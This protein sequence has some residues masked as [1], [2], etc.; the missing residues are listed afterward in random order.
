[1]VKIVSHSQISVFWIEIT[2]ILQ[3]LIWS[4]W[5]NFGGGGLVIKSCLTLCG[6][7]DWSLLGSSVHGIFQTR[8]LEWVA[9][10]FSKGSSWPRDGTSISCMSFIGRQILYHWATWWRNF[11]EYHFRPWHPRVRESVKLS[12]FSP[13]SSQM[14]RW[15]TKRSWP[16]QQGCLDVC[17][18]A[19]IRIQVFRLSGIAFLFIFTVYLHMSILHGSCEPQVLPVPWGFKGEGMDDSGE[20]ES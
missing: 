11:K 13:F 16:S 5:R 2:L 12:S 4:P 3:V 7:T 6:P 10:S 14:R 17:S 19:R 1:M 15:G 18:N 8:I 9:I 20:N